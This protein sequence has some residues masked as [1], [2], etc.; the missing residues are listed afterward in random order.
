MSAVE[1]SEMIDLAQEIP[2]I[3]FM[4][5][6]KAAGT[7]WFE[8]LLKSFGDPELVVRGN[9]YESHRPKSERDLLITKIGHDE[10]LPEY[11]TLPRYRREAKNRIFAIAFVRNPFDRVVSAFH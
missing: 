2:E 9:N 5:V 11:M 7:S 3:C 1:P 10:A 4:H 6:P 8:M